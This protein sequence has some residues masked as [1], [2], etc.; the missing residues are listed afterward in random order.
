MSK[1]SL[2]IRFLAFLLP[3]FLLLGCS[4]V[5]TLPDY[6]PLAFEAEVVWTRG[7]FSLSAQITASEKSAPSDPSDRDLSISFLSPDAMRGIKL[8]RKSREIS[9]DCHGMTLSSQDFSDWLRVADLLLPTGSIRP[10]SQTEF[11]GKTAQYA[12]IRIFQETSE[13]AKEP[14][15]EIYELILD[16]ETG[17][18]LQIRHADE[19]LEVISFT[20]HS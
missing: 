10:I 9:V 7:D 5:R 12:E 4:P 11:N 3:I 17:F 20:P 6:R 14:S 16:Q 8:V 1:I 15:Y 2:P 13:N 18:P 19:C